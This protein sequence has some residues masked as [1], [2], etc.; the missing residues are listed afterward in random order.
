MNNQNLWI[1]LL[2]SLLVCILII[3]FMRWLAIA[4]GLIDKP[5]ERKVHVTPTPLIGGITIALTVA[6]VISFGTSISFTNPADL[7]WIT[8]SVVM[9]L[10]GALDDRFNIRPV[11]RLIV[12]LACAAG[13][14][15][16][17][18]RIPSLYGIG[19]IYELPTTMQYVITI[20]VI[21]GVVNAYNLMDGIDGLL[22]CLTLIGSATLGIISWGLAHYDL[23]IFFTVLT[24]ATIGFL[25]FNL[26]SKKIF[27]GDAGS[28]MVGFILITSA[29]RLLAASTHNDT[30][31]QLELLLVVTGL[32]IVPVFDSL[33]VYR[34]RIK[35]GQSP[36]RA[37]KTHLHHLLLTA[38]VSHKQATLLI[39]T[40]VVLILMLM[41]ALTG[42]IE[43]WWVVLVATM[44]FG[45]ASSL[46]G[47][48]KRVSD[49]KQRVAQLESGTSIEIK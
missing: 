24:G 9:L 43:W 15:A 10:T 42:L 39:G 28:L 6:I 49:W 45:M 12:Q 29:I 36:F 47:L 25:R 41:V 14:A 20:M 11:Y 35:K 46:L 31:Q 1:P 30:E 21:A 8:G 40:L 18:I 13:V 3:P 22:G 26:G 27:M 32:F 44:L 16:A 33:R 48:R 38:G 2:E 23:A 37:D 7:M 17:G 34:A 4:I 19:G 5:N